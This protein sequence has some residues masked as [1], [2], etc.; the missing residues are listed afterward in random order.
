MS[1]WINDTITPMAW[2]TSCRHGGISVLAERNR[3][4][5]CN[6]K[7]N[8]SELFVLIFLVGFTNF[9]EFENEAVV[10]SVVP[11]CDAAKH[12]DWITWI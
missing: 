1:I 9:G 4:P 5:P 8:S 12:K 2:G 10:V 11:E 6:G 3:L 7:S